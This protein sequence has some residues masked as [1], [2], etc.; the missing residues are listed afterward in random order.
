MVWLLTA[1]TLPSSSSTKCTSSGCPQIVD[2]TKVGYLRSL[3]G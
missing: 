1:S 3:I 2:L